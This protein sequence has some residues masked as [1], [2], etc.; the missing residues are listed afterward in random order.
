MPECLRALK[1][2]EFVKSMFIYGEIKPR[3]NTNIH[4]FKDTRTI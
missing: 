3:M 1:Y 4:K 2:N